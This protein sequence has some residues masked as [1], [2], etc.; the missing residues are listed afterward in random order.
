MAYTLDEDGLE[1]ESD[2]DQPRKRKKVVHTSDSGSPEDE[3]STVNQ[4]IQIPNEISRAQFKINQKKKKRTKKSKKAKT[5][6]IKV[7]EV[8]TD[9]ED[10]T[11]TQNKKG[12][13]STSRGHFKDPVPVSIRNERRWEFMCRHC[14][15]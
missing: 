1:M 4:M 3:K 8:S 5:S 12:P 6:K 13:A 9:G 10:D 2:D 11:R 7:I 15:A 14:S